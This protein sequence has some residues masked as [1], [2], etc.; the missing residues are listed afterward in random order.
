MKSE[1]LYAKPLDEKDIKEIKY[2]SPAHKKY[3]GKYGTYDLT[4]AIDFLCDIG[5]SVKAAFNGV[6]IEIKDGITKVWQ[7]FEKPNEDFMPEEEQD[8][9]YIVIKHKNGE[10]TIYS[11]LT[12]RK[13]EVKVGDSVKEG[14]VIGYTG[15]AV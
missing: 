1:N 5:K 6:V 11:H 2:D 3:T 8:G 13:I 7:K 12:P 10:F 14:Q 9:N 4:N 15:L